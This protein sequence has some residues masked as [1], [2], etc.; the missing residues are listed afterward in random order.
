MYAMNDICL[1]FALCEPVK[2]WSSSQSVNRPSAWIKVSVFIKHDSV[3]SQ[4][5]QGLVIIS[6][7]QSGS[8]NLKLSK[9]ASS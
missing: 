7:E 3:E 8:N 6:P 4:T 1:E 9:K 2:L 5:A